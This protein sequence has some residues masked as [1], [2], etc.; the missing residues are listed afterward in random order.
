ME[1]YSDKTS[2]WVQAIE[3]VNQ[4]VDCYTRIIIGRIA[5]FSYSIIITNLIEEVFRIMEYCLAVRWILIENS[6]CRRYPKDVRYGP[7]CS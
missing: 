4:P 1:R 2:L 5:L 3:A 6:S 7:K